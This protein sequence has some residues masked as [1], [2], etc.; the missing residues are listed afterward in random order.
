VLLSGVMLSAV[1][2]LEH[3]RLSFEWMV[4]LIVFAVWGFGRMINQ[5]LR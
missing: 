5:L 3:I 1:A 2:L 4:V